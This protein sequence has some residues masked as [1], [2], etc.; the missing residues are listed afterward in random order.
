MSQV[1]PEYLFQV[2]Q[3]MSELTMENRA[4]RAQMLAM[5]QKLVET[6]NKIAEL[7]KER[8]KEA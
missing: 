1:T 4:L 2:Y 7:Q 8:V 3:T 6:E 5:Q